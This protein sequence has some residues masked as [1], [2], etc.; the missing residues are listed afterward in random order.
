[1]TPAEVASC[2]DVCV[3]QAA[4]LRDAAYR[5]DWQQAYACADWLRDLARDIRHAT[6]P[7]NRAALAASEGEHR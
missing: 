6:K 5:E 4:K 7:K 2:A 3:E 1:M